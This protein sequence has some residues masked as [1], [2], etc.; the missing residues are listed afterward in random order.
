MKVSIFAKKN[1]PFVK[2][3]IEYLKSYS[4]DVYIYEGDNGDPFPK[5]AFS[6]DPGLVI[7]YL[8]P[9]IIPQ[10]ILSKANPGA[11]NFHPGPPEYPG[12]GCFNFA[13]YNREITYGVTAHKMDEKVD[14]G[15]I[16]GVKRFSFRKSD[17]V[18]KLSIKSYKHML[19]LFYKVVKYINKYNNFPVCQEQW[20]RKPYRRLELEQL[21]KIEVGME[22]E[23]IARRI[24]ATTYPNM[25]GAY[26]EVDRYK[27]EYNPNR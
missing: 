25:P 3:V 21:C 22:K 10:E 23:E 26:L 5:T 24:K 7:S 17:S 12:I 14:K 9:W 1:K 2:E 11:I 13:I 27:F 20:K 4:K 8:S 15:K 19:L 6:N 16:I 18:Y